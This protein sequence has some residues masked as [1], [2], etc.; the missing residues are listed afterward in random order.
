MTSA[1]DRVLLEDPVALLWLALDDDVV[2]LGAEPIMLAVARVVLERA[3]V[4]CAAVESLLVDP[5]AGNS[6]CINLLLNSTQA[7]PRPIYI[8][9]GAVR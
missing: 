7:N 1:A 6:S 4:P 9:I 8:L 3:L 5:E 2:A